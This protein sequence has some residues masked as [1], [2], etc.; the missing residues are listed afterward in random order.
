MLLLCWIHSRW[1]AV[2]RCSPCHALSHLHCLHL[3]HLLRVM[4]GSIH[5]WWVAGHCGVA[6]VRHV[7]L[8]LLLLLLL[9]PHS[10]GLLLL[11]PHSVGLLVLGY[12]M[13][14][15]R[16]WILLW[17]MQCCSDCG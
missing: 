5:G 16:R 15:T 13:L 2:C 7:L 4:V 17:H 6:S 9:L 14:G 10:L 11:F 8:L 12:S 1:V 3:L